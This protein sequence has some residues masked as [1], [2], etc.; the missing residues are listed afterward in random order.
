MR[1]EKQDLP[2]AAAIDQVTYKVPTGE[3]PIPVIDVRSRFEVAAAGEGAPVVEGHFSD[4]QPAVTV[5][6]AG[7]GQA[8]YCGFLPGLSYFKP[9]IPLRPVDRGTTDDS[10]AH[11]IPT[12]FDPG[13]S[14]LMASLAAGLERPVLSSEPLVETTVIRAAQGAIVSLVNWSGRPVKALKLSIPGIP[15]AEAKLAAGGKVVRTDDGYIFDLEVAD[16]LIL[17]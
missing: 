3:V 17:R 1:L 12:A 6:T 14:A 4:G 9:A 13:A 11:F 8:I 10:M 16:A 5:R 7:K 15:H 2:F